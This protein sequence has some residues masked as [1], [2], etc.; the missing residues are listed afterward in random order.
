MEHS[1][2]HRPN[3]TELERK[4]K[5]IERLKMSFYRFNNLPSFTQ[6]DVLNFGY[7]YPIDNPKFVIHLMERWVEWIDDRLDKL[8]K[9]TIAFADL[10]GERGFTYKEYKLVVSGKIQEED[11]HRFRVFDYLYLIDKSEREFFSGLINTNE[12]ELLDGYIDALSKSF[13]AE[14]TVLHEFFFETKIPICYKL[15]DIKKHCYILS[16]SGTGKSTL[17][18][19]LFYD[20]QRR[21]QKEWNKSMVLIEPHSDLSLQLMRFVLNKGMNK[22]RIVY[23]DP[24]IRGTAIRLF[25]EDILGADYHFVINPFELTNP[26]GKYINYM[27]QEISNAFFEIIE[28]DVTPQMKTVINS[29]VDTL[30]RKPNSSISDLKKFMNDK[31]NA[32]L[33]EFGIQSPNPE[34]SEMMQIFQNAPRLGS[35]K[36]AVYYRLQSLLGDMELRRLLIGKN[37]VNLEKEIN[38]GKVILCNFSIAEMGRDSAPAFGKLVAALMLG[39]AL[40]RQHIPENLRMETYSFID[41]FQTYTTPSYEQILSEGRKFSLHM[42]L[43]NQFI[44][45]KMNTQLKRAV[46]S[47]T[48]L[49]IAGDNDSDSIE[50]M[51]KEMGDLKSKD[52]ENLPKYNFFLYNKHNKESGVSTLRVPDY[53]VEQKPPFYM[54][55]NELKDLF[56][57][58]V[59]ESGYYKKVEDKEPSLV[60]ITTEPIQ[61][62]VASETKPIYNPKFTD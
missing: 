40:K 6:K 50:I 31:K 21:S 20:L 52:F 30:L 33:V 44:G 59:H 55:K 10:F 4:E 35:T 45:Q 5:M 26:S 28:S 27:A 25:G 14:I 23:L 49:K 58:M 17:I 3:H 24:N 51:S 47:N 39:I 29:C 32:D 62:L 15:D 34:I 46:L 7:S 19:T 22:K 61:P 41:E 12:E 53:L 2:N 11:Y 1:S 48:V 37:T 36:S 43:S 13:K 57:Y 9:G 56:L 60:G 8:S 54:S 38:G 16:Q 42:I 18:K